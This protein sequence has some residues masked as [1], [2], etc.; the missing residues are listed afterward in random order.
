MKAWIRRHPGTFVTS[1]AYLTIAS[2]MLG[3]GNGLS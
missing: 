1:I 3:L 2:L